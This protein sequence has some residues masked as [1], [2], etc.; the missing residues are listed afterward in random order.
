MNNKA[1]L[2]L[3]VILS[4]LLLTGCIEDNSE[5]NYSG[6]TFSFTTIDGSEMT[7]EDFKGKVVVADF[8]AT[9]CQ[10]CLIEMDELQKTN[11]YFDNN[12]I[13]IISISVDSRDTVNKIQTTFSSYI[14]KWIFAR[15]THNMG[16][17]YGITS[18]PT[19]YIFDKTGN[20][21]Y[22]H[23]GV[24]YSNTLVNRIEELL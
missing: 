9:W 21:A 24:T 8:M 13:V 12:E 15:D 18:I 6:E 17:L 4:P 16:N 2:V 5:E 14:N 23:I 22:S 19:I 3:L 1:S 10:P 20:I 7:L 11:K